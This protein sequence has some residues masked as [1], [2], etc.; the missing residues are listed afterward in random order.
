MTG[1]HVCMGRGKGLGSPSLLYQGR[2]GA[3]Q[4]PL[5]QLPQVS[6]DSQEKL[7]AALQSPR[8][9]RETGARVPPP[10]SDRNPSRPSPWLGSPGC[11]LPQ[12]VP[13]HIR[14]IYTPL[15]RRK[16][17]KRLPKILNGS[18]SPKI[19]LSV[20]TQKNTS[21]SHCAGARRGTAQLQQSCQA[22]NL[23]DEP[24]FSC[25]FTLTVSQLQGQ[26]DF[27]TG[28]GWREQ[29]QCGESSLARQHF[30]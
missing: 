12:L 7:E 27:F 8:L 17:T 18:L 14:T 15:T 24:C 10:S 30:C 29:R 20:Q 16:F 28:A 5:L 9:E 26:L 4:F 2:T 19:S 25:A 23:R 21:N 6:G 13:S 3:W 22:L 11:S 1:H